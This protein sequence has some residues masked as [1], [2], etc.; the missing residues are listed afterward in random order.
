MSTCQNYTVVQQNT[1]VNVDSYIF[2]QWAFRITCWEVFSFGLHPHPSISSSE[3]CDHVTN[4]GV[5]N[6][7]GLSSDEMYGITNMQ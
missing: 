2:C 4:V 6:K 7:P 3:I 1:V 5:P